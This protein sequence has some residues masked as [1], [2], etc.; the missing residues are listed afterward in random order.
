VEVGDA[1]LREESDEVEALDRVLAW[2]GWEDRASTGSTIASMSESKG[3]PIIPVEGLKLGEVTVKRRHVFG[4]YTP[5]G[6]DLKYFACSGGQQVARCWLENTHELP[7]G[8]PYSFPLE[9]AV[10]LS[11]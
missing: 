11:Q 8:R 4:P 5:E 3:S 6:S 7:L 9:E 10:A 1:V 2:G